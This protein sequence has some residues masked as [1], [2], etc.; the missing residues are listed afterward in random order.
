MNAADIVAN[1]RVDVLIVGLGPAGSAAAAVCAR[2]GLR[3]LAIDKR[4]RLG[5]P[6]QCAE[7]IPLPLAR[8]AQGAGVAVQRIAGMRSL[9][10]S[11]AVHA[12]ALAG[13]MVDRAAFDRDLATAA[14]EAGAAL[15]L[16]TR[17]A[18]IDTSA[19]RARIV[20]GDAGAQ[21]RA[22]H[23]R[24]LIAADGPHSTV[25]RAL[26]LAPLTTVLTRQYT[27]PLRAACVDTDVWLA[28]DFPGGYAWLFPKGAVANIGVGIDPHIATDLKTPLARIHA[29]ACARGLVGAEVLR[30]TGGAIPV[31]GMRS[32]LAHGD[33][34]FV[35]DAAGLTHPISGAGIAAAVISGERAGIAAAE[36]LQS[37]DVA[38]FARFED[39]IREQFAPTLARALARRAQLARVW[40]TP[41]AHGD[42]PMRRGWIGFGEYFAP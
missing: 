34:L 5:E 15:R 16:H 30:R 10:P 38:A 39:D 37:G 24:V 18:D 40:R 9:L 41:A 8:Y 7:F 3:V 13:V 26:G 4:R 6:V 19:R 22:I 35:G 12:S 17:L 11:G 32:A 20:G 31:G 14:Q 33:T 28:D 2:A 27:V 21:A 42:A 23:Y 29:Q 36:Y 1:E 25:A